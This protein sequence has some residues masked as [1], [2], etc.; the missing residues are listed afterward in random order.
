MA[1]FVSDFMKQFGPDV[2][3]QLGANL[4]LKQDAAAQIV[5]QIIPMIMGGLKRQMETRGG[6]ERLDH[7]LRKSHPFQHQAIR[8][9]LMVDAR[10]IHCFLYGHPEIDDVQQRLQHRIDDG[11]TAWTAQDHKELSVL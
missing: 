3:R 4:G 6:P 1:D 8:H 10:G 5:P 11:R 7:I 9:P 2:S